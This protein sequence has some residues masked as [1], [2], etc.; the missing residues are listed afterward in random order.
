MQAI[1]TRFIGPTNTRGSRYK[2]SCEAGTLTVSADY[3]L[4]AEQNHVAVCRALCQQVADANKVKYGT[5]FDV[6]EM[7]MVHGQIP[8]GEYVHV[9]ATRDNTILFNSFFDRDEANAL[10]Y[11]LLNIDQPGACAIREPDGRLMVWA[12]TDASRDD[13]GARAC[14]RSAGTI[15]DAAWRRVRSLAWIESI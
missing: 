6:W 10:I 8:S 7:A 2:A 15:S 1:I 3:E 5:T 14:Y 9:F 4:D 12:S 13:D 11:E